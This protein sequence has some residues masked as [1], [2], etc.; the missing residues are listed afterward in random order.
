[1]ILVVGIYP[2]QLE[3]DR[4]ARTFQ[5]SA[6]CDPP[7]PSATLQDVAALMLHVGRPELLATDVMP[8]VQREIAAD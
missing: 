5:A 4:L 2:A 3:L 6:E 7:G 1:M 8:V